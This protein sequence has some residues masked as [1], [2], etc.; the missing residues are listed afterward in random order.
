LM[1]QASGWTFAMVLEKLFETTKRIEA[2]FTSKLV[3]SLDPSQPVIDSFVLQNLG[4]KLPYV[5]SSDRIV[6]VCAVY[7]QVQCKTSNFLKTDAGDELVRKFGERYPNVKIS[8][9]KMLDLVLWQT[10]A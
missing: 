4:L 10:R 6:R 8:S 1:S 3:A 9:M 5:G 2:S 7:E